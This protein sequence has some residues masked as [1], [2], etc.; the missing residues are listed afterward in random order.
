MSY[1]PTSDLLALLQQTSGGMRSVRMPGLDWLISGMSRA[2]IFNLWVAQ[3]PPPVAALS[4]VWFKTAFPNSGAAEGKAFIYNVAAAQYQQATPQLWTSVFTSGS[5]DAGSITT[6]T[7]SPARLPAFGSG[8]VSFAAAGG[9]GTIAMS[10]VTYAK[11][12]LEGASSLLGN[13]TGAPATV[14]EVTLDGSFLA[15]SAGSVTLVANGITNTKLAQGAAATLKGNPT[16]ALANEQDFTIQGLANLAAPSATLDFIP[17]YDH[18][19]GAIKHVTPGAVSGSAGVTSLGASTGA[20]TLRGGS[21]PAN[22]LTCPRYDAAETLTG[23]EK[24]QIQTNIGVIAGTATQTFLT[25][26][27]VALNNVSNYFDIINTGSVGAA[28][29]VWKITAYACVLDTVG[30]ARIN[31]RIWDGTTVYAESSSATLFATSSF[32]N[33]IPVIAIVT[34]SAATTFRL[35]CQDVTS[36]NGLVRPTGNAGTANKATCIIAE[37]VS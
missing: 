9:A 7:L 26:S 32:P 16:A 3:T 12:Q 20:V 36:V 21:L 23:P 30:A 25:G 17:I 31:V 2:N 5:I 22:E 1:S 4:T 19:A 11:M 18:V 29:Q 13:P 6:G 37:R 8:D 24:T 15:F 27:D 34:L 14:S 33:T 35:S 10:A 28:G